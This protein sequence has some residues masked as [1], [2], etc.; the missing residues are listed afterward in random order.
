MEQAGYT[1]AGRY[2]LVTK[3][4]EGG[5]G[6]VWIADDIQLKRQVAVKLPLK[7]LRDE[8]EVLARFNREADIGVQ[9]GGP[10]VI[11]ILDRGATEE[12]VPYIVMELLEGEDL[13]AFID[14]KAPCGMVVTHSIVAQ[15]CRVVSRLHGLN[16]VHRDIKP[17]NIFV[18]PEGDGTYS[19]KL[20]DFGIAK[21][22]I[23][24]NVSFTQDF[25]SM[26]SALYMAPEQ[27]VNTRTVGRPSDIYA[28]GV[29]TYELATGRPPFMMLEGDDLDALY[30]RVISR[31][32][33]P[34]TSLNQNLPQEI[35]AWFET[36][37]NPDPDHRFPSVEAMSAAL[38][39]M[40]ARM[41]STTTF[42]RGVGIS[43]AG[44]Q[45]LA[46]QDAKLKL[47]QDKTDVLPKKHN[48]GWWV[49]VVGACC[50]LLTGASYW[51]SEAA[52]EKA[53]EEYRDTEAKRIAAERLAA[54]TEARR[55]E[56]IKEA[57][58]RA[59]KEAASAAS[60]ASAALVT[61]DAAVSRV[62]SALE[63]SNIAEARKAASEASTGA[64]HADEAAREASVASMRTGA[65]AESL[66]AANRSWSQAD[67]DAKKAE[68]L[69]GRANK[70]VDDAVEQE[71]L[72]TA[73]KVDRKNIRKDEEA[74]ARRA[75]EEER[76]RKEAWYRPTEEQRTA[77][78]KAIKDCDAAETVAFR[79]LNGNNL[80]PFEE[81]KKLNES[82]KMIGELKSHNTYLQTRLT[83]W[84][85]DRFSVNYDGTLAKVHVT[86]TWQSSW[87]DRETNLC[88]FRIKP[89]AVPQVISLRLSRNGWKITDS[90]PDFEPKLERVACEN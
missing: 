74:A 19:A 65:D 72:K 35:D 40:V 15:L 48:P 17:G 61:V 78:E 9:V 89:H 83:E 3:I 26:G 12:G 32:Y 57:A 85:A 2:T 43:P 10:N 25:R 73:S 90:K 88:K 59:A 77:L 37:L 50:L 80:A 14:H 20:L 28:I 27:M 66:E 60:N 75:A 52:A 84:V 18:S 55:I 79:S 86:E 39:K 62:R 42:S 64:G 47:R 68:Q 69:A 23:P 5:M 51:R 58:K 45:A 22:R 11:K 53:A 7:R 34:A 16:I 41:G 71:R 38:Q 21:Q 6:T 31:V 70:D 44:S 54:E 87:W 30:R 33:P 29:V 76:K 49:A 8:P 1:I 46:A 56:A 82:I 81:G 36:A 4:N 13:N 63:R 24:G 67:R